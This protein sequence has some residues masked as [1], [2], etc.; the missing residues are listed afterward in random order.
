M[1]GQQEFMEIQ[2]G[3]RD[4]FTM[5]KR[6]VRKDGV[7]YWT[8]LSV[9]AVR[10]PDGK[11]LYMV[12]IT[13]DIDQQKHALEDLRESEARFRSMFEHSAI[14]IGVMGLDRRIIDANPAICRMYGRTREEMIGMNAAQVTYPEDDSVS[15]QLFN[16]LVNGERNSY[17][18]DRRYIRKNGEVFWTHVTMSSVRGADGKPMYLVGMV[19]DIDEQKHAA[20]ELHKSQAQF[21][22]IF[23]NVAVGVAVMTL[24]RRPIAFNAATERI[25]GYSAE[26]VRDIDPRTLALPEDRDQDIDHGSGNNRGQA[27]LVCPGTTV[28]A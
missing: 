23:D 12:A 27:Q 10:D 2:A 24:G 14:G 20:E 26:E 18:M 4:A 1:I 16:E 17:E 11:L 5:E 13:E 28:P 6:F 7:V 19:L 25:I 9:S 15:L 3:K 21:Q 8:R 22:A